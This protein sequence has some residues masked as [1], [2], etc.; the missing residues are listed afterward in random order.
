MYVCVCGRSTWILKST[1]YDF[2]SLST[3]FFPL[4]QS[5]LPWYNVL[6][7]VLI[8]SWN[9]FRVS[10]GSLPCH[11]SSFTHALISHL[12]TAMLHPTY[13]PIFTSLLSFIG[14]L[15]IDTYLLLLVYMNQK[16]LLLI[17]KFQIFEVVSRKCNKKC[18]FLLNRKIRYSRKIVFT[19]CTI[20][21]NSIIL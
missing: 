16:T 4:R 14:W 19:I 5:N 9:V 3:R 2:P 1:F 11:P 10:I 18:A 21:L 13:I 15:D 6:H 7:A 8:K 17:M 20:Y 12:S